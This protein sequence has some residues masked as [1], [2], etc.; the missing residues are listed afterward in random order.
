MR[1][2]FRVDASPKIGTGHLMRCLVLAQALR[3][4][5]IESHFVCRALD[6]QLVQRI[7][8]GGH[9]Y[10]GLSLIEACDH[11]C[12]SENPLEHGAWL[13]TPWPQDAAETIE[14]IKT[15]SVDWLVVDHYGIDFRWQSTLRDHVKRLMVIDDL[16]DRRHACD[17]LLDQNLVDNKDE[18]YQGLI[19]SNCKSLLGPNYALLQPQYGQLHQCAAPRRPPIKRVLVFFGGWDQHNL[20]SKAL[21][22]LIELSRD[23]LSV[24]VVLGGES[25]YAE[26]IRSLAHALGNVCVH[27]MLPSLS[28]LILRADL[29]IGAGGGTSWERLCL[30]LPTIVI[31]SANN[32]VEICKELAKRGLIDWVGHFDSLEDGALFKVLEAA[33]KSKRHE[34]LSRDCLDITDGLGASRVSEILAFTKYATLKIRPALL[35]DEGFLLKWKN[36]AGTRAS[37]FQSDL[38]SP[39]DHR[40]WFLSRLTDQTSRI[41]IVES[42]GG[43]E[44]GQARFELEADGWEVHYSVVAYARGIGLGQRVLETAIRYHRSIAPEATIFGKVRPDNTASQR[45]FEKLGFQK[46]EYAEHLVF[47]LQ[48]S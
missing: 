6:S 25:P 3:E 5:G 40:K 47:K 38:I 36:D 48:T 13:P 8:E 16:A 7:R 30:G 35:A 46:Y 31:S 18:R 34:N 28:E 43:L 39:G 22:A 20:T 45:I 41:Y 4:R 11:D 42:E 2:A 19:P 1:V 23:D 21:R 37:S 26:E 32:Q 15:D 10:S 17:L 44:I 14:I 24:D 29:A 27:Q 12:S 9:R 33:F